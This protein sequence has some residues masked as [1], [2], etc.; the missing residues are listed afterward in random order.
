M[1]SSVSSL[2]NKAHSFLKYLLSTY[3]GPAIVLGAGCWVLGAGAGWWAR[4]TWSFTA[5]TMCHRGDKTSN[6]GIW[7]CK[8]GVSHEVVFTLFLFFEMKIAYIYLSSER[9]YLIISFPN[10][11]ESR[12]VTINQNSWSTKD[13]TVTPQLRSLCTKGRNWDRTELSNSVMGKCTIASRFLLLCVH[14][15]WAVFVSGF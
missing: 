13:L 2:K 4:Q 11:F 5:L 9:F 12:T 6:K 7:N 8:S 14:G 10:L 3:C 15:G 1:Q